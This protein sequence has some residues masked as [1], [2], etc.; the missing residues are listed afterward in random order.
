VGDLDAARAEEHT[1]QK[2]PQR[3]VPRHDT[4]K[5]RGGPRRQLDAAWASGSAHHGGG[6]LTQRGRA[7]MA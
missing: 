1:P 7:V 6:G 3:S 2:R 5:Q 4:D